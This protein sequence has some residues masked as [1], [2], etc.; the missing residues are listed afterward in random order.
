MPHRAR[1]P[2]CRSEDVRKSDSINVLNININKTD[3]K[4]LLFTGHTGPRDQWG[5]QF[6]PNANKYIYF[7]KKITI[8]TDYI[9]E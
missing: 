8:I 4:P 7:S 3:G 2:I 9:C 5:P 1:L 6:L